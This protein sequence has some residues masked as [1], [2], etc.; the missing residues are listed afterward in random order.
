M[1]LEEDFLQAAKRGKAERVK[2]LMGQGVNALAVDEDR[3]T[4]LHHAAR[5][6]HENVVKLFAANDALLNAADARG[7]RAIDVAEGRARAILIPVM[8]TKGLL[9]R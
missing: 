4:A 6:G 3:W 9:K 7:R 1:T 8:R 5:N 2:E